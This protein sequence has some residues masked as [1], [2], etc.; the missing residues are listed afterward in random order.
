MSMNARRVAITILP[1]LLLLSLALPVF[2]LPLQTQAISFLALIEPMP[3]AL[4]APIVLLLSFY[5]ALQ[6]YAF[7]GLCSSLL[8]LAGLVSILLI[9][10]ATNQN[11]VT[12]QPYTAIV[13]LLYFLI[14]P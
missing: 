10:T 11:A 3:I 4:V 12:P 13:M 1:I 6:R 2:V 7:S 5:F 8:G 14:A 9:N